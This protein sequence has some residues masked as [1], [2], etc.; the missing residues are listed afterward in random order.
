MNHKLIAAMAAVAIFSAGSLRADDP[1]PEVAK[2]IEKIAARRA[3]KEEAR[4]K[5][6]ESWQKGELRHS[7]GGGF[8]APGAAPGAQAPANPAPAK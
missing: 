6:A 3:A 8:G 5:Q 2:I 7:G 1:N 4:T